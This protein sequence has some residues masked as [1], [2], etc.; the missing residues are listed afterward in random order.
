M[1]GFFMF[2]LSKQ[3]DRRN[4]R[5]R[6]PDRQFVWGL[7]DNTTHTVITTEVIVL[8][9]AFIKGWKVWKRGEGEEE[10]VL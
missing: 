2:L 9:Q 4:P 8:S 1:H 5:T 7:V 6:H 10:E 3:Y